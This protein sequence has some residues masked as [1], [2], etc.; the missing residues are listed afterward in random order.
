MQRRFVMR[1]KWMFLTVLGCLLSTFIVTL[2]AAAA[3]PKPVI[4]DTDMTTDDFMAIVYLLN[5]SDFSVKAITVTGT[6]WS[7]CDAGVQ[8]ALGMLEMTHY[9]DV[10]VSCWKDTPWLGGDNPV[11]PDYRTSLESIKAW[12]LPEGGKPADMDAVALFTKTVQD[13]PDKIEVLALGP[14]TNLAE[15]FTKTPALIDKIER[16]TV[17]GGAVDVPGSAVSDTNTTAEWNIY[18]DPPAARAVFESGAPITLIALDASNDVPLTMDFLDML[19]ANAKTDAAKFLATALTGSVDFIK[20]GGY[21]FWDP[22]AAAVMAD[23]K[24]VTHTERNV[25]VVDMPGP[26]YGRTK[27]VGN[28]PRIDVVTKPDGKTFEQRLV[29]AWNKSA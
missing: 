4:I 24:L 3:D 14:L 9:S 23:P 13:A 28:G 1:R 12:N 19:N 18:C 11:N 27:P 16:L 26:D 6:G 5:N 25:T 15:A 8:V 29:D 22:L 7:Y 20:S 17:M 2:P 10:P 21:F